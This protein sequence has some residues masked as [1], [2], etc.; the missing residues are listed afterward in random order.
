LRLRIP[1]S[2]SKVEKLRPSLHVTLP[3][4][5]LSHAGIV[6]DL[7]EEHSISAQCE[8]RLTLLNHLPSRTSSPS[9]VADLDHAHWWHRTCPCLNQGLPVFDWSARFV[10]VKRGCQRQGMCI[11]PFHPLDCNSYQTRPKLGYAIAQHL[12]KDH[13]TS[14]LRLPT[15][16]YWRIRIRM[17]GPDPLVGSDWPWPTAGSAQTLEEDNSQTAPIE[18]RIVREFFPSR[19]MRCR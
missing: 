13:L 4:R 7:Y 14:C 19:Q 5:F 2:T 1:R 10:D 18:P 9:R 3:L 6:L 15:C 11:A 8:A 17:I 12:R 16:V